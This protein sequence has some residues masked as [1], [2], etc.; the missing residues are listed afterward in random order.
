M[1]SPEPP[2]VEAPGGQIEKEKDNEEENR[3]HC[4]W[5]G[6]AYS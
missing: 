5:V 3:S 4:C 2:L 6:I 1:L